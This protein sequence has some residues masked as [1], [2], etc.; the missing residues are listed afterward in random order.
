[1]LT[2]DLA[3][4]VAKVIASLEKRTGT[5]LTEQQVLDSPHL[6]IGS[7]ARLTEKFQQLR[8]DLGITSFLLGEVG[9]LEACAAG[10][11]RHLTRV[12]V[13]SVRLSRGPGAGSHECC[14]ANVAVLAAARRKEHEVQRSNAIGAPTRRR[15]ESGTELG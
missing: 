3:G 11:V 10:T 7:T 1:M 6:F 13:P 12:A 8:E 14:S 9:E 5:T 2:D 4:E 15:N